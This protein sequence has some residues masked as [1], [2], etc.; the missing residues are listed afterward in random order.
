MPLEC[1]SLTW[2][3]RLAAHLSLLT[4]HLRTLN[5]SEFK[6]EPQIVYAPAGVLARHPQAMATDAW[7]YVGPADSPAAGVSLRAIDP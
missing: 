1:P 6:A 2:Q 7:H 5:N 3:C 4:Q